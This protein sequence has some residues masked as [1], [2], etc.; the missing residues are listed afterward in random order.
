MGFMLFFYVRKRMTIFLAGKSARRMTAC[1]YLI[2]STSASKWYNRRNEKISKNMTG[3]AE[4][5]AAEK[6]WK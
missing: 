1:S 3:I 6:D 5:S 4:A 2:V